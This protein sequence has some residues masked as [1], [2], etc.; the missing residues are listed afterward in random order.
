VNT[1]PAGKSS[2][3]I[4]YYELGKDQAEGDI[5]DITECLKNKRI[6]AGT[7]I[8][9]QLNLFDPDNNKE[10]AKKF[11]LTDERF[12]TFSDGFRDRANELLRKTRK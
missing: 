6:D 5:K 9:R 2:K 4:D 1:I 11:R 8:E 3:K 10:F 12:E 7:C